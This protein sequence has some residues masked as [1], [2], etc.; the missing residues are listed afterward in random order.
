MRFVF[1]A[2]Y[3]QY[4]QSVY[5]AV[6][7]LQYPLLY[8]RTS[9]PGPFSNCTQKT[10]NKSSSLL[11]LSVLF[12]LF[13]QLKLKLHVSWMSIAW[14]PDLPDGTKRHVV[15]TGGNSGIGFQTAK[16]LLAAGYSVELA[17]RSEEK[18]SKAVEELKREL[19]AASAA[20][21]EDQVTFSVLD[22]SSLA[23]V[24]AWTDA[25]IASKKPLH[26]LICNAGIMMGPQRTSA[27]GF[28]LQL[29]TNYLYVNSIQ[30]SVVV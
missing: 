29:A 5:A 16:E 2:G 10:K 17:C 3:P 18:A 4:E 22:V 9:Y 8:T 27:D 11:R 6:C 25:Y 12:L 24:V 23:S 21:S 15:I 14:G 26:V 20:E 13:P 28:E 7:S 1:Y 19:P 30:A